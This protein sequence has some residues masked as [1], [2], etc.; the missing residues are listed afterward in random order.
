MKGR[1]S[2]ECICVA[3]EAANLLDYKAFGGNLALKLDIRKAFDTLDWN[4][5]IS[6]LE[7]FRFNST[8]CNWIKT[9]LFFCQTLLFG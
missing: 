4:F 9:I 6:V 8:F 1:N 7:T 2:K 5:I 3:S